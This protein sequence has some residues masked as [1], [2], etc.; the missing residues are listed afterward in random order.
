M[1]TTRSGA[2]LE[3]VQVGGVAVLKLAVRQ[4][5]GLGACIPGLDQV[6]G[7]IDPEHVCAQSGLR[8]S[9]RA[10]AAAEIRTFMPRATPSF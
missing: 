2:V 4:A 1:L 8:Q 7:D 9:R 3:I 6:R 10:V 5:F